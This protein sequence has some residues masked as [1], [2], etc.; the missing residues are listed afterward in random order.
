MGKHRA[1]EGEQSLWI[2]GGLPIFG[3]GRKLE[4]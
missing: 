1:A 3:Q 4:D 2:D